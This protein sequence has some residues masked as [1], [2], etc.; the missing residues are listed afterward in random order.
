MSDEVGLFEAIH[1]QRAL[2]YIAPTGSRFL[3]AQGPRRRHPRAERRQP[4]ALAL[5]R[6]QGPGDEEW[7]QGAIGRPTVRPTPPAERRRDRGRDAETT[8]RQTTSPIT[9]TRCPC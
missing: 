6:D 1:T 2:R 3:A 7:I 4:A 5:H 8:P 9:S